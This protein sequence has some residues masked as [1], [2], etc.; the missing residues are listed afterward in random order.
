[1]IFNI[2]TSNRHLLSETTGYIIECFILFTLGSL[3]YYLTHSHANIQSKYLLALAIKKKYPFALIA[4]FMTIIGFIL[5]FY[6]DI[7]KTI[8]FFSQGYGATY[9]FKS[10]G[11]VSLF[12]TFFEY[13]IAVLLLVNFDHIKKRNRVLLIFLF[14]EG[15]SLIS[16]SRAKV[17]VWSLV[18][19]IIYITLSP[20]VKPFKSIKYV[21]F[22]FIGLC[23]IVI[24]GIFRN[25]SD[26]TLSFFSQLPNFQIFDFFSIV[27]AEM[28]S[29]INSVY[30][31]IFTF[32]KHFDF[33]NG[34]NYIVG[35]LTV[36]PN[37]N[38]LNI[39]INDIVFFPKRFSEG[40]GM[41]AGGSII[42]ETYYAFGHYGSLLFIVIGYY[43]EKI[44]SH[45]SLAIQTKNVKSFI[46]ILP[47]LGTMLWWNRDYFSSMIREWIWMSCILFILLASSLLSSK[48]IQRDKYEH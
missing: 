30:N 33:S 27:L 4:L 13:G 38:S 29:T 26:K 7:N 28:G 21:F 3:L 47:F 41:F 2:K 19:F 48:N 25:S 12:S 10:Y 37:I 45:L 18:L 36:F 16:G 34:K 43:I 5:K 15:F 31:S 20:T 46:L 6:L 11:F 39:F 44:S 32:P 23:I 42:G 9:D 1:M 17:F 14:V 40:Y 24:I 22:G 35:L 8:I